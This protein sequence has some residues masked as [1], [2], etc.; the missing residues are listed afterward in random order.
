MLM[1]EFVKIGDDDCERENLS[2]CLDLI[3][4]RIGGNSCYTV[5]F[6]YE[7]Y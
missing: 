1:V 3:M 4:W 7:Y 6:T 5:S 2:V